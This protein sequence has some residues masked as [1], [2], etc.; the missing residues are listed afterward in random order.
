MSEVKRYNV[1]MAG[2]GGQGVVTASHILSNAVV[3]SKGFS[4]LVPFFGSE[5]RNAPVESYVRISNEEIFEIGEIVYPNVLIIFSAQVITLGKSYTMPFYTG[6]KQ[7]GIILI[8]N[9]KPL[10]FSPDETRELEEKEAQI[11]FLPATE[12]ANEVAKTELA[13]NMAMCGAIAAIFG[14]PNMESLEGSVKDRFIGKGIVVSG[15]TAALD[16]V[17]EKK[18]AKKAKLLQANTDA[19]MTAYQYA[20]DHKWGVHAES[21]EK[22]VAV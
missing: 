10:K 13:T 12:M 4:S 22:S 20:V 14:M 6:L 19:L 2:L 11:Y 15:G 7:G 8:N 3:I 17:I 1:R 5:K 16:S 21:E 9:N 18:F